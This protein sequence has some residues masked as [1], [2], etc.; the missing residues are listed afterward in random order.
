[1]AKRDRREVANRMAT[2][3]AHVLKW[4]HQPEKRSRSWSATILEQQ[5]QLRR[6]AESG[7]LRNHAEAVLEQ[8]FEDAVRVAAAETGLPRDSFP[9]ECPYTVEQ[10]LSTDF[11]ANSESKD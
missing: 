5:N 6:H 2:H 8:V 7:V 4:E 11:T 10:L 9:A 3:L 1:M